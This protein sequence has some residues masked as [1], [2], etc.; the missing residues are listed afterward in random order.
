MWAEGGGGDSRSTY[1]AL[2]WRARK[3][4]GGCPQADKG[5]SSQTCVTGELKTAWPWL[6]LGPMVDET[7]EM[8]WELG[9]CLYDMVLYDLILSDAFLVRDPVTRAK[10]KAARLY[11]PRENK[12]VQV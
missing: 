10:C 12:P 9:V 11:Y 1:A 4:G 7:W 8:S 3:G 5:E 2:R 6:V